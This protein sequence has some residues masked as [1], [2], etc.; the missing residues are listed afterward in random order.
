MDYALPGTGEM[1]FEGGAGNEDTL[2]FEL[3]INLD[4]IVE[5]DEVIAIFL[6]VAMKNNVVLSNNQTTVHVL[7]QDG[8]FGC[9][10]Q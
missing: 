2:L 6:I 10:D 9:N 7:D 3:T 4:D 5:S 8:R 1:R